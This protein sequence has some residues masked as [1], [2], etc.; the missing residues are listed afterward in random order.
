MH[1]EDRQ[2]GRHGSDQGEAKQGIQ[3]NALNEPDRAR[4]S[5]FE[6]GTA[7]EEVGDGDKERLGRQTAKRVAS[8]GKP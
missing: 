3:K 2:A 1:A 8:S 7:I 6:I 5:M 4:R